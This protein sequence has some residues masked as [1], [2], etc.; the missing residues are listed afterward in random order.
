M[1]SDAASSRYWF[2]WT[3]ARRGVILEQVF[4]IEPEIR[5]LDSRAKAEWKEDDAPVVAEL[6]TGDHLRE[7]VEQGTFIKQGD[8]ACAEGVKYDFRLSPHFLKASFKRP[9]DARHLTESEKKELL[10]EPGEV[11]FVLTEETL[12]LP[13]DTMAQLS[14]KRKLAHS[15]ILTLGGFAVDP[16]YKGPLL[17]GLFNFSSTPFPLIPGK[18]IIAATFYRLAA[19]EVPATPAPVEALTGFPDELVA[20]MQK[21]Q[22]VAVQ[23]VAEG[24]RK[25]QA[26][27]VAL[28]G[29][30]RSHLD[31]YNQFKA[32]LE[33]NSRQIAELTGDIQAEKEVRRKGEDELTKGLSEVKGS[34]TFLKGA[35][36]V[37]S[38]ILGTGLVVA[39]GV[40]IWA[41][42][43][44][45]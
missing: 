28:Q 31:W 11:V 2:V 4:V 3:P 37:I 1:A 32:A 12:E 6:V 17:I 8:V 26:E 30:V 43:T 25:L 40:V 18:K 16:G 21:Y 14:P 9:V 15:G 22:P 19:S 42:T 20:V 5:L 13:Y 24:V 35:A 39:V 44:R 45:H 10:V 41:L 33:T 27:L 34:L 7:A 29:E 36:W 23:S 38:G